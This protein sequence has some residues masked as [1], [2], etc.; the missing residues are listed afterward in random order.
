MPPQRASARKRPKQED[1]GGKAQDEPVAL[2]QP[3]KPHKRGIIGKLAALTL[4]PLDILFE[5]CSL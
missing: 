1:E 4:M 3:P 5:V 2:A